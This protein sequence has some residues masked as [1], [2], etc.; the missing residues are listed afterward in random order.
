[1]SFFITKIGIDLGTCNSRIFVPEKGVVLQEPSVIAVSEKENKILAVGNE[2]KEMIG[3]TPEDIN[4]YRPL[5]DG[6]IADFRITHAM[7]RY[8]LKKVLPRYQFLKPEVVVSVPAGISSTEKR[9]VAEAARLAGA[10]N[11]YL[12][13]EPLLAA[14]GAGLPVQE[15]TGSMIVNI[16]GGTTEVA[17]ISLG[18]LVSFQSIKFA[19]DKMD[20]AIASYI[21]KKKNLA[22]GQQ[23]AEFIKKEIGTAIVEKSPKFIEIKGNDLATGLPKAI[24]V[25][26]NEIAESIKDVLDEIVKA[27][28]QVLRDTPPE[29]SADII[30]KGIIISGGGALLRNIDTYLTNEVHIPCFIAEDSFYCVVKGTGEIIKKLDEYK[31]S[32][33]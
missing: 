29:L 1:M 4:V 18:G 25:S 28:K 16:G 24:K 7:F 8:F 15:C 27:V 26:S 19:G 31:R 30:D 11:V 14:I 9:A 6:V 22:I 17:I 3:K 10:K 13:K 5:K 33:S 21:K 23:T 20:L 32:I 12:V 2:A